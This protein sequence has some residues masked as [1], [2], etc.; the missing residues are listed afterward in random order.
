MV[1]GLQFAVTW[2]NNQHCTRAASGTSSCLGVSARDTCPTQG[3]GIGPTTSEPIALVASSKH[4]A[5]A[6]NAKTISHIQRRVEAEGF[7]P[8]L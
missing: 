4:S 7:R 3:S 2:G 5:K 1:N 6:T 8:E